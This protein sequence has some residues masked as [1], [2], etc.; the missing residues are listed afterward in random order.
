MKKWWTLLPLLALLACQHKRQADLILYNGIVYT[1]NDDFKVTDAL[2]IRDGKVLC[3]GTT[4]DILEEF[5]S[6]EKI[7]LKGKPVYPGFI[8]SHCHFFGYST[9]LLKCDLYGTK[10]FT[11]VMDRLKAFDITNSF[12]W[13]LGRGWDQNDWE[14]KKFPDNDSLNLL[15]P[16]K[17]VYLMRID[18]HAALCNDAALKKAGIDA[19]TK[20]TGGEIIVRDGKPTGLLVDNAVDLV[21]KF[22]PPFTPEL[23]EKALMGGQAN[24]FAEGLTTVDDAGLEKDTIEILYQLQKSGKLKM[25]IYAMLADS[26]KTLDYFLK[27]GT[28]KTDRLNVRSV[29]MYADGALGS[30]GALLKKPYKDQP[31]HYGFLL[32]SM[33]HFTEIADEAFENGYQLCVHAIGDSAN[34]LMLMLYDREL[35]GENNRR[36]RIEHCQVVSKED[37]SLF[38]KNNVIASVQPTHATS[39]MYWAGERLGESRLKDAYSY[40]DLMKATENK[41]VF[42]TD[43][44]VEYISPIRTF[45]A[46]VVRKDMEGYPEKGFLKDNAVKRK[47]ALRAMTIWGAYGNFEEEEK[48]SLEEDKLADFI[49]LDKDIMTIMDE[50]IPSVKVLA[51]YIGGEKVFGRE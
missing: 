13:L 34:K 41:I 30:R 51:T 17:P 37:L 23:V 29:K 49:I 4:N 7:D 46:A 43:F 10:S 38:A 2:V 15:Y 35:H 47:D 42:G 11:E 6:S 20:I 32:H 26:R 27:K 21:K 44:P 39:D 5:D 8:D 12:S 48:G 25:R 31:G 45:Y 22:I 28:L 36:W 1:V 3:T 16:D 19:N 50:E 24:C 33:D 9:D 40:K 14:G 18:G